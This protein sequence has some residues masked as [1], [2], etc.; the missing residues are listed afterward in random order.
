VGVGVG[1]GLVI[2]SGVEL[3]LDTSHLLTPIS[4]GN[5]VTW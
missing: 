3:A 2:G 1:V 5:H 4:V